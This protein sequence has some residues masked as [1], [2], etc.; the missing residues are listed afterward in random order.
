MPDRYLRIVLTVIAVELAWIGVKDVLPARVDA[1]A[2]PAATRVV[3][4]GVDLPTRTQFL[5]VAIAGGVRNVATPPWATADVLRVE[6]GDRPVRVE[7][8]GTI[9]ARITEPIQV[10]TTRPLIVKSVQAEGAARPGL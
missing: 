8:P 1:Q 2:P 3:I 4:A 10:D 7:F 9:N 5:P 6:A